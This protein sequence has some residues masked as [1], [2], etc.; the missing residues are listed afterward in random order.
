MGEGL[1]S[2][3]LAIL[4]LLLSTGLAIAPQWLDNPIIRTLAA[5]RG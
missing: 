4:V 5:L 2:A 1:V 3:T